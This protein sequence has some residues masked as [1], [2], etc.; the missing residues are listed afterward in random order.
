MLG[1][2]GISAV[3]CLQQHPSAQHSVWPDGLAAATAAEAMSSP[4]TAGHGDA[5]SHYTVPIWEAATAESA[6]PDTSSSSLHTRGYADAVDAA[7]AASAASSYSAVHSSFG[8]LAHSSI[9]KAFSSA[10][11]L[12]SIEDSNQPLCSV[13]LGSYKEGQLVTTLSC[14][15]AY[16]RDCIYPWLLQQGRQATCPMCKAQVFAQRS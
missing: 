10:V 11:S 15:H 6:C 4:D 7:S 1:L 8:S 16:H 13:C 3:P 5:D 14:G 12:D 9:L 2:Q